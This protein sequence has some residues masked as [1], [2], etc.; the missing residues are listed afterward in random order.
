MPQEFGPIEAVHKVRYNDNVKL[1]LQRIRSVFR[2]TFSLI[3]DVK[4]KE[5]QAVEL[6]GRSRAR[7][8]A[9]N[10]APTPNIPPSHAGI[11]VKPQRLDWGRTIPSS[12]SL[13]TATQYES[14]YVQEGAAAM[15]R[16]EDEILSETFFGIRLVAQ[17]DTGLY[18]QVPFDTANQQIPVNYKAGGATGLTVKK[19]VGALSK[20]IDSEVDVDHEEIFCA[21]T[22]KQNEDLYAELQVSSKDYRNKAIFED[23]RVL[24]FMGV[25]LVTYTD[26]PKTGEGHRRCPFWLKSGMHM[27]DALPIST[28]IERNPSMQYQP[29]PYMEQWLAATRSE[30]EKVIDILCAEA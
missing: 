12:T 18:T 17:D 24:S 15:R 23:K 4:G 20:F 2:E 27:G 7:R 9:P 26:L 6:V 30:D 3:P 19:F 28:V 25:Q 8:N 29:H 11:W 5:A 22:G 21:I 13:L 16:G 10:N 1:A 14:I